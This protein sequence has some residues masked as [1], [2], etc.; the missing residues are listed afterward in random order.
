[1]TI[2]A[3][4]RP[5]AA[6]AMAF[7]T[8]VFL[9][10]VDAQAATVGVGTL[11]S[12]GSWSYMGDTTADNFDLYE[13]SLSSAIPGGSGAWLHIEITEAD[14]DT[15]LYL[16]AG[17][18]I[19]HDM[20]SALVANDDDD[21][22]PFALTPLCQVGVCSSIGAGPDPLAHTPTVTAA[23]WIGG[24]TDAGPLAAGDYT[25]VVDGFP[26]ADPGVGAYKLTFATSEAS[27]VPIPAALPLY[28]SA[29]AVTG[30]M[31]WRKKRKAPAA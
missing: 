24:T 29:L 6:G 11:P 28:G 23:P 3:K 22:Q 31:G 5:A 10:V 1:M 27:V 18:G 16:Y 2:F 9:T 21:R 17:H 8:A 26:T 30:F 12:S 15:Y 25:V 19:T 20:T 13:F 4:V 7:A 14:F